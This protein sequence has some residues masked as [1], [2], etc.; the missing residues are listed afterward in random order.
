MRAQRRVFGVM[1]LVQFAYHFQRNMRPGE[2]RVFLWLF[3]AAGLAKA[4]A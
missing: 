2:S 1:C 3:T 4:P